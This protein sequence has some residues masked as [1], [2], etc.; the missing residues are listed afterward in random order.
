VLKLHNGNTKNSAGAWTGVYT[1]LIEISDNLFAGTSGAQ[2]VE[3]SP[4]NGVTDERLRNIVVE[5][6]V[7]APAAGSGSGRELLVGAVNA[8]IRDNA[9]HGSSNMGVQIARRGVE[10][11]PQHVEAYNNTCNGVG[12][13]AA[14]SGANFSEA[15]INSW[16]SNNLCYGG[17][18][19]G[20]SGTG[21]TVSYNTANTAANPGFS[22]GSGSF[23]VITDFMPSANYTG[24]T[25]VADYYDALGWRW[26]SSW[27]L[28]AIHP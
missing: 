20:N 18:C 12:T 5:R 22:N 25:D 17:S 13:C 19:V 7:F 4:Q 10:P 26:G 15:G 24:G 27:D 8:T 6:N 23:H 21:N 3:T 16:A 28:G 11:V 1:E 9:F 14:F 2:L